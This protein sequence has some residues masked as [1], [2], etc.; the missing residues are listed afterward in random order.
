M[1]AIHKERNTTRRENKQYVTEQGPQCPK[2]KK[3][4][5]WSRQTKERA[6]YAD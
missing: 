2:K 5:L 1:M 6:N 3:S 4:P